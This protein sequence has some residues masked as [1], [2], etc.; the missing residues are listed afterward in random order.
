MP[1]AGLPVS[2]KLSFL[3]MSEKV[4]SDFSK[5]PL[6]NWRFLSKELVN[7]RIFLIGFESKVL[8]FLQ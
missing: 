1:G 7:F 6:L 3:G 8:Y 4:V 5:I 2:G